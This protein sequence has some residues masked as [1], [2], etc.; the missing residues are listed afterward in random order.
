MKQAP[1]GPISIASPMD[2][3]PIEGYK[4]LKADE[5]DGLGLV[6]V[7]ALKNGWSLFGFTDFK[8]GMWTQTIIKYGEKPK[9][10]RTF[11]PKS[12]DKKVEVK[13]KKSKLA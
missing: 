4:V 6:I 7:D 1:P 3:L 13:V 5:S 12:M 2:R 10:Q 9:P 11:K 8:G